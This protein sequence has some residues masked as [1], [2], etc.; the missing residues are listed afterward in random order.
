MLRKLM[1]KDDPASIPID[2]M[3]LRNHDSTRVSHFYAISLNCT[4]WQHTKSLNFDIT[5]DITELYTVNSM[6]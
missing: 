3:L 2:E 1:K 6:N 4:D 5:A